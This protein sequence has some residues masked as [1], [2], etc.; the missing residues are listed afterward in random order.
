MIQRRG[1]IVKY[2]KFGLRRWK[3]LD[4]QKLC[5]S[6]MQI[7][8]RNHHDNKYWGHTTSKNFHLQSKL[9]CSWRFQNNF[10][11][12]NETSGRHFFTLRTFDSKLFVWK[13]VNITPILGAKQPFFKG[14]DRIFKEKQFFIR[15][16]PFLFFWGGGGG[17][18]D[19]WREPFRPKS[20]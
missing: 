8:K 13:L 20:R 3:F 11:K 15:E 10:R 16:I 6:C 7:Y 18:S 1:L 19:L 17:G 9:P 14:E 4:K 2:M 5:Q 12:P